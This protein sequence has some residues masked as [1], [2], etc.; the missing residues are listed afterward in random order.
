MTTASLGADEAVN[1]PS[2]F[3]SPGSTLSN[4]IYTRKPQQ[5]GYTYACGRNTGHIACAH[6]SS[7]VTVGSLYI[8]IALSYQYEPVDRRT[9]AG[10]LGRF[11]ELICSR[12]PG[13]PSESATS[14]YQ[15]SIAI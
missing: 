14:N 11:S 6:G 15:R 12:T 9:A 8:Y 7:P 5:R 13:V 1:S 10:L 3:A 2:N 4:C